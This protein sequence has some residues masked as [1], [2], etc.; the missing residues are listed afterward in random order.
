[1]M[2][3]EVCSRVCTL[4]DRVEEKT[5]MLGDYLERQG[6]PRPAFLD[7]RVTGFGPEL[8]LREQGTGLRQPS[9]A[10]CRTWVSGQWPQSGPTV[11]RMGRLLAPP[12][13]LERPAF[14]LGNRCSVH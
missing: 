13:R 8:V 9:L 7:L 11:S 6:C 4:V 3:D 14:G 12:R 5:E 2:V 10:C 1:M